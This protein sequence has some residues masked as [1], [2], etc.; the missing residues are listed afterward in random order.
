MSNLFTKPELIASFQH[1]ATTDDTFWSSFSPDAFIAKPDDRSWSPAQNVLHL[2]SAI[3]PVVMALRLP[4]FLPR[5]LFGKFNAPSRH[6]DNIV[7]LYQK[8]LAEGGQASGKYLPKPVPTPSDP[9][10]YQRTKVSTLTATIQSLAKALE[11]WTEQDL[12]RIQLPH[13]LLGKLTVRE[14][15]FFTLYHLGHH[16]DKVAGKATATSHSPP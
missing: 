14:M 11:P 16:K 2:I 12:D 13:P 9:V 10:N 5:L 3:K 7:E 1:R 8:V 15:L 4:R 6:Y